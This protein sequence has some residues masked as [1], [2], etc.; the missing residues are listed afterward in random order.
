MGKINTELSGST[1]THFIETVC[2]SNNFFWSNSKIKIINL[3][4]HFATT[5]TIVVFIFE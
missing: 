1:S 5:Y 3:N 4:V 2:Q